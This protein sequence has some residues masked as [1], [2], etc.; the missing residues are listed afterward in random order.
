MIETESRDAEKRHGT[1]DFPTTEI[2]MNHL[3]ERVLNDQALN[4][5]ISKDTDYM[6]MSETIIE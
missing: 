3:L 2:K 1:A 5:G 4:A 6:V